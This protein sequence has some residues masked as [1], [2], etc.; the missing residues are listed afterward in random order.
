VKWAV[1]GHN[2]LASRYELLA[3][4]LT[5][6]GFDNELKMISCQP[7]DLPEALADAEK[8]FD[9]IRIEA[10]L[11]ELVVKRYK[12]N[13][14]VVAG[15]GAADCV[16]HREGQWWPDAAL[17]YAFT[18]LFCRHGAD[19]DLTSDI[20]IVGAGAAAR[21]AIA[22][23]ARAGFQRIHI[24]SRLDDQGTAFL[25]E[26]KRAYF[27]IEFNFVPQDRLVLL[28]GSHG[29]LVNTTPLVDNNDLLGELSYLNFLRPDGMIWDLVVE[30]GTTP[31][32]RDGEQISIR[33]VR[34]LEVAAL[35]D[36]EWSRWCFGKAPDERELTGHYRARFDASP[37]KQSE[38]PKVGL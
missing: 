21:L 35:A 34:G 26:L 10:P 38:K 27:G 12:T 4:F 30:P 7:E 32:I 2:I 33:C 5:R 13:Q 20:L 19:M 6:H 9:Q 14:M 18:E 25:G 24:T 3:E 8:N 11:R 22:A 1:L 28:P 36:I 15:L 17:F 23:G 16:V 31:L 37:A 29:L